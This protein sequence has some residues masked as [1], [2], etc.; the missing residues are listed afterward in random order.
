MRV[1]CNL[2]AI[3]A[4]VCL[5]QYYSGFFSD[6][7]PVDSTESLS[8]AQSSLQA[9]SKHLPT[10]S[11]GKANARPSLFPIDAGMVQ[12]SICLCALPMMACTHRYIL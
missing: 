5:C 9:V 1:F 4:H 12:L 10:L 3:T 7:G 6:I 8:P 2:P 11:S